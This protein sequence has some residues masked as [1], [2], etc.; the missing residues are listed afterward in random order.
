MAGGK[1]INACEVWLMDT[2]AGWSGVLSMMNVNTK[3]VFSS[4]P[5]PSLYPGITGR[6]RRLSM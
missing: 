6:K 5:V 3:E 1:P 2:G 4:D